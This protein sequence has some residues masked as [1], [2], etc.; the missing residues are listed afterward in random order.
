MACW[1][2]KKKPHICLEHLQEQWMAVT[3][4]KN[5]SK[6]F[7]FVSLRVRKL[8]AMM[9][10]NDLQFKEFAGSGQNNKSFSTR[11]TFIHC[12]AKI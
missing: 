1:V 8:E 3:C 2:V 10:K 6:N 7:S 12:N 5:V 11:K 9:V 4:I